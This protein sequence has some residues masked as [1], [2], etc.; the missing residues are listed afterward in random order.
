AHR[1]LAL[2]AGQ[3][4][5]VEVQGFTRPQDLIAAPDSFLAD[6]LEAELQRILDAEELFEM[7]E[8]QRIEVVDLGGN[9]GGAGAELPVVGDPMY[10]HR[11]REGADR[12]QRET[13]A[14]RDVLAADHDCIEPLQTLGTEG[15]GAGG[16]VLDE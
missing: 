7:V 8:D 1:T 5:E 10:R 3:G 14:R 12:A 15:P 16:R 4:V 6:D 2:A 13:E 9:R 11:G